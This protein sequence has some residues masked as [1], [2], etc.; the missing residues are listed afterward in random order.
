MAFS[1]PKRDAA[2]SF[3]PAGADAP[4]CVADG[5]GL[6]SPLQSLHERTRKRRSQ[7]FCRI[8]ATGLASIFWTLLFVLMAPAYLGTDMAG[9]SADRPRITHPA[10][11]PAAL[12]DDAMW[13]VVKRDGQIYFGHHRITADELPEKI[14]DGLR[15]GA[16]KRIYI[17]ADSRAKYLDVETVLDR[18]REAGV[19]RVTFLTD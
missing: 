11:L 2:L 7:Y 9:P 17:L 15:G 5:A 10:P 3:T 19:E 8:D 16:E 14:R 12:R 18:I 4:V 6:W 1:K 13:V